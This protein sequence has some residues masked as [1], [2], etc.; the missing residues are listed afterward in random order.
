MASERQAPFLS[1]PIYTDELSLLAYESHASEWRDLLYIRDNVVDKEAAVEFVCKY[2]LE[3]VKHDH[4]IGWLLGGH[5]KGDWHYPSTRLEQVLDRRPFSEL[6]VPVLLQLAAPWNDEQI[7]HLCV[8]PEAFAC[9]SISESLSKRLRA[10]VQSVPVIYFLNWQLSPPST[11]AEAAIW[12]QELVAKLNN[13]NFDRVDRNHTSTLQKILYGEHWKARLLNEFPGFELLPQDLRAGALWKRILLS[14]DF[15]VHTRLEAVFAPQ[16]FNTW[17]RV[18]E[19]IEALKFDPGRI[20]TKNLTPIKFNI[21]NRPTAIET[22]L[23]EFLREASTMQP[24]SDAVPEPEDKQDDTDEGSDDDEDD[25][26]YSDSGSESSSESGFLV[27]E[28]H[29]PPKMKY[30][31]L[32]PAPVGG[33]GDPKLAY[34]T[35]YCSNICTG[36]HLRVPRHL[37]FYADEE[38]I[39]Y[40]SLGNLT[41]MTIVRKT[42][43]TPPVARD[44]PDAHQPATQ[45]K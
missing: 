28:K 9:G 40:D 33:K 29:L 21:A 44:E 26:S 34:V 39:W 17:F 31:C 11:R 15:E 7:R 13:L 18:A 8:F 36:H 43:S 32:D 45:D 30:R 16:E 4:R 14:K 20:T 12:L 24:N 1:T 42:E 35:T 22:R 37:V 10:Y 38:D 3:R 27:P 2:I 25:G 19:H 6:F 23:A 41:H 5:Q